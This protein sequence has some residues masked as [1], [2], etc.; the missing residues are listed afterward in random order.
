[1][2]SIIQLVEFTAHAN[3]FRYQ[4]QS[5]PFEVAFVNVL[6]GEKY[7]YTIDQSGYSSNEDD[8]SHNE[9][10]ANTQF[11][12]D[13]PY[14]NGEFKLAFVEDDVM[15][16]YI[17]QDRWRY[18]K[19]AV[20]GVDQK[21]YFE[22]LGLPVVDFQTDLE[23]EVPLSYQL[24]YMYMLDNDWHRQEFHKASNNSRCALSLAYNASKFVLE[25]QKYFFKEGI[26][27]RN[28]LCGIL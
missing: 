20:D 17:V 5:V 27:K 21:F 15:T 12:V 8:D 2:K 24:E 7:I 13:Y 28:W 23:L 6:T 11:Y 22:G 1:M 3:F 19:V 18:S 16:K 9:L 14:E 10:I 25:K 26:R 4:G